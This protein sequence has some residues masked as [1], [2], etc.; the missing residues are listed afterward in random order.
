MAPLLYSLVKMQRPQTSMAVG[1]GYSTLH[2]LKA[3]AENYQELQYDIEVMQGKTVDPM[4]R[5]VLYED[6]F[7]DPDLLQ[8]PVL[9]GID[10]FSEQGPHLEGLKACVA[11]LELAPFFKLHQMDFQ[12]FDA[13]STLENECVDFIWLDCGHQ[14]DYPAQINKFWPLLEPDG[15]VMAIHYTHVDIDMDYDGEIHKLMITGAVTNAIKKQ[16]LTAQMNS[17]FE[18][19]SLLEPHKFDKAVCL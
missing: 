7:N 16:Q 18:Y 8:Q 13:E 10:N 3:L 12:D 9:H 19:I 11:A 1:L 15:G 6:Y 2:I 4:R 14:L 17:R 5:E